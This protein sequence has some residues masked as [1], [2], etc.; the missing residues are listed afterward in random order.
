MAGLPG[1]GEG[2]EV[3]P[4]PVER[5]VGLLALGGAAL[6]TLLVIV[7]LVVVGYS[8]IM[9]YLLGTPITGTDEFAGYAVIAIVMLGAGDALLKGDHFGVDL[10][11]ARLK[12]GGRRLA[13]I[14]G[15]I[16]V[17]LF[18]AAIIY[19]AVLMVRFSYGF[20][21]YSAGYLE[22]PMW[23]PQSVLLAGAVLLAAATLGRLASLFMDTF[24][25]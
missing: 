23:I 3:S 11:T 13:T 18:A 19:S 24:R 25:R 2:D 5:L 15:M 7:T 16:A 17:L 21:M 4:S 22:M 12:G 20:E 6:A 8:V 10:L 14:W 9:R 1:A